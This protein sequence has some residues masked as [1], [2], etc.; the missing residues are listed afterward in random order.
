MVAS[1]GDAENFG[2]G[3]RQHSRS[4]KPSLLGTSKRGDAYLRAMLI[5]GAR[6]V[7]CRTK[8]VA[9]AALANKTRIIYALLAH[10]RE[11]RADYAAA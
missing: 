10:D 4:D 11:F 7:I 1:V 3:A 8:N 6:W 5:H 9:A 2:A